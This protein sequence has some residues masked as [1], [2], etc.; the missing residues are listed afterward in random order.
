MHW[1]KLVRASKV[2][3]KMSLRQSDLTFLRKAKHLTKS[4]IQQLDSMTRQNKYLEGFTKNTKNVISKIS[5]SDDPLR[6]LGPGIS[7]YH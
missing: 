7:T 3:R 6:E 4:A 1:N 5:T 2:A